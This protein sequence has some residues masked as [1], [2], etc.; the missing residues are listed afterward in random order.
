M[1]ILLLSCLLLAAGCVR[2][3]APAAPAKETAVLRLP[4][5]QVH[6]LILVEARLDGGPARDFI[7]DT[8]A[9]GSVITPEA[10]REAGLAP[11]EGESAVIIAA[12]A[13]EQRGA[14]YRAARLSFGGGERR[15]LLL[16]GQELSFLA[17][18]LGHP[19]GGVIG[20][21]VLGGYAIEIDYRGGELLLHPGGA[22]SPEL[23]RAPSCPLTQ[24]Q[25]GLLSLTVSV[26][27]TA[28]DTILD[29]GAQA[30]SMNWPAAARAGVSRGAPDLTRV[31]VASGASGGA[32]E[33]WQKTF[34]R[35]DLC[36][37][38]LTGVPLGISDLPV[39]DLLAGEGAPRVNLG[40]D[41]LARYRPVI[42]LP[43]LTL[44]LLPLAY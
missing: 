43:A 19:V 11:V 16:A 35:V 17:G 12:D 8:G 31:G 32:F 34:A 20:L 21:D 24:R 22:K 18:V 15:D 25:D 28:L 37:A 1:R 5:R 23:A 36:G 29:L 10:A 4:F 42:D 14:L 44:Y 6:G 9:S 3:K 39:D 27:G 7:I 30:T 40:N 2:Q 26:E 33:V 41:L 38:A 13:A